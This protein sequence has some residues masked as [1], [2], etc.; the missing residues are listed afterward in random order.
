MVH[1]LDLNRNF[2]LLEL[3]KSSLNISLV[4][5]DNRNINFSYSYRKGIEKVPTEALGQHRGGF[6]RIGIKIIFF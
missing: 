2:T 5:F 3:S 1:K 6:C 4:L